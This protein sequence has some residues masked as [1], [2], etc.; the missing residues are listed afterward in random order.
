[1]EEQ[2][3][4]TI[5][6]NIVETEKFTGTARAGD[7]VH[8]YRRLAD[9]YDETAIAMLNADD[10]VVGYLNRE[11]A[12]NKILLYLAKGLKFKCVVTGAPD[13]EGDLP[14]SIA[15]FIPAAILERLEKE[16]ALSTD[17]KK[18]RR[19]RKKQAK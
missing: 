1:M 10:D 8:I 9:M 17:K 3:A 15:V 12:A 5:E 7:E 2:A 18:K 13:G 11:V 14:I 19:T 4:A 16:K 6:T